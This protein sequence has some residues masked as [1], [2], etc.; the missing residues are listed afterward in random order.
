TVQTVTITQILYAGGQISA[1]VRG[2]EHLA[3][4]QEW[5]RAAQFDELEFITKQAY[6]DCLLAQALVRVA[7]E[8]VNTFER[9]LSDAEEMFDVGMISSFEVLRARTELGARTSD[10]TSA[11]NFL[12]L[13]MAN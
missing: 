6:Y 1:A 12:R 7:Q 5:Q 4:A 8:S 13:N 10:L 11:E 9:N 2:A 3:H